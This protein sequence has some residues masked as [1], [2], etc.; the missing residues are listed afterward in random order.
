MIKW[1]KQNQTSLFCA[2]FVILICSLFNKMDPDVYWHIANGESLLQNGLTRQDFFSY[3]EGNFISHEWLYDIIIYLI[4]SVGGYISVKLFSFLCVGT[5]FFLC[6]KLASER[7]KMNPL[8]YVFPFILMFAN[9][10]FLEPRPQIIS[11]LLLTVEIYLLEKNKYLWALPIIS[12]FVANTHGGSIFLIILIP[13]IYLIAQFFEKKSVLNVKKTLLIVVIMLATIFITPYGIDCATYGLTMPDYVLSL[14]TEW[15]VIIINHKDM[16]P[17]FLLLVPLAAMAYSQKATLKDILMLCLGLMATFIYLR[18]VTILVPL[19]IVFGCPHIMWCIEKVLEKLKAS[20]L[21][22]FKM[23]KVNLLFPCLLLIF[24]IGF[25]STN[26][27]I[28][29]AEASGKFA[30]TIITKYIEENDIDVKNNI[31]FNNY[32]FGGYLIF[33]GY[34]TFI[35]GRTDVFLSEFGNEDVFKDYYYIMD[36]QDNVDE[37][38]EKYNI[39]YYAIYK[40]CKLTE[41]LINNNLANVLVEDDQYILHEQK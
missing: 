33:N 23:P 10:M 21:K 13:I 11:L 14:V 40:N 18:M 27:T 24:L 2:L 4:Y 12:L 19:Y 31:M 9:I 16:L 26:Y 30:P 41:Y 7:T 36:V 39:K 28:E 34:K 32:N 17:C 22:T 3:W 8:V 1:L 15:K 38:I 37:L 25:N 5:A 20:N 29:K 6:F 35:D